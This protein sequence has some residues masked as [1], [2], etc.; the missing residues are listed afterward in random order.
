[1]REAAS[2]IASQ[3]SVTAGLL[4]SLT[5]T[6]V[7]FYRNWRN[8]RQVVLLTDLDDHVLDDI[9]V[10]RGD[11]E[12]A[13]LQPFSHDPSLQLQRIALRNRARWQQRI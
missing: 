12:A 7:R 2:F 5:S 3:Q 8:R 9:G 1:M 10:T 13:L 4:S 11:V 6:A